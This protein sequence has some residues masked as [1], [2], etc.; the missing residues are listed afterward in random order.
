MKK[1]TNSRGKNDHGNLNHFQARLV[2]VEP[3]FILEID[4]RFWIF[5]PNFSD[6]ELLAATIESKL[7]DPKQSLHF[8][9]FSHI[10]YKKKKY[11]AAIYELN[12][13]FT[14]TKFISL[15]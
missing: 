3:F 13:G 14:F 7:K 1:T 15:L 10:Q 8:K 6:C 12:E 9:S 4:N 11:P 2:V 5:S